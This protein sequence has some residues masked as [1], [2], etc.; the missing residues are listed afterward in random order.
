MLLIHAS[1]DIRCLLRFASRTL[2]IAR[3]TCAQ[4]FFSS[5]NRRLPAGVSR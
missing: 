1:T 2:V 5:P 4:F 3:T